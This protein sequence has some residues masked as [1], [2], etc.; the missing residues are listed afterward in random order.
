M[1][2]TL[3]FASVLAAVAALGGATA[4]PARADAVP[5]YAVRAE[6]IKG[7]VTGFDGKYA[8]TVR[9]SRGYTDRV[10][11][12]DGTVIN[13]RGLT[14][15]GG[16]SVTIYGHSAGD[17]FVAD[18]VDTPY[19]YSYGYGPVYAPAPYYPAPYPYYRPYYGYYPYGWG[20]AYNFGFWGRFR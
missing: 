8:L 18:E 4:A 19:H 13:P 3:V 15:A 5:G 16:M 7:V 6:S 1:N 17:R 9:D 20:P 11:L 10:A 14:L 2:R 12:H